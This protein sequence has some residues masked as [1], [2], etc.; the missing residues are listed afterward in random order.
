MEQQNAKLTAE[1]RARRDT[2]ADGEWKIKQLE[3]DRDEKQAQIEELQKTLERRE[4]TARRDRDEID[5]LRAKAKKVERAERARAD[6]GQWCRGTH[7]ASS[8]AVDQVS[9]A[10]SMQAPPPARQSPR[11]PSL[12][13]APPPPP[14]SLHTR[15]RTHHIVEV[16]NMALPYSGI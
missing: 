3:F 2:A 5:I 9:P 7:P 6:F 14:P 13:P 4:D 12:Q 8:L 1:A 16:S 15:A 10:P 11:P